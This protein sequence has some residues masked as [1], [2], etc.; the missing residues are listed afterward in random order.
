MEKAIVTCKTG[1]T[2]ISITCKKKKKPTKHQKKTQRVGKKDGRLK[3]TL[4]KKETEWLK[5]V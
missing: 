3:Q 5:N 4:H 1:Q 2:F